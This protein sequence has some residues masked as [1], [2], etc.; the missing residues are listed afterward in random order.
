MPNDP[1]E[2]LLGDVLGQRCVIDDPDGQSEQ[3]ALVATDE[4]QAGLVIAD[5]DP[6][7]EGLIGNAVLVSAPS[8]DH[9]WYYGREAKKDH[10]GVDFSSSR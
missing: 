9:T 7:K 2:C 10:P 5:R 6:R 8:S 3:A 4:D 1:D